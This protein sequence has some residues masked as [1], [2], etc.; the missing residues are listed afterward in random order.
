LYQKIAPKV[1]ELRALDMSF[2]EIAKTLGV[3]KPTVIKACHT[4]SYQAI[5]K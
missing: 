4:R 1:A 2:S 3:T 5:P